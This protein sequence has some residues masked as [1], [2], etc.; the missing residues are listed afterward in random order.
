MY[1]PV[2]AFAAATGLPPE[3]WQAIGRGDV[4]RGGRLLNVARTV[5][6][7]EV[8]ELGKTSGSRRRVPLSRRAL[9]ALDR[10]PPRLETPLLF[11]AKGGGLM[12]LDNWRRREWAPAIEASGVNRPRAS[13][14]SA[15]GSPRTRS[16]PGSPCSSWRGSWARR[17]G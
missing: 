13:T 12:N 6:S 8:V 9:E 1:R 15:R 5:S 2:P 10:L 14:I 4:D 11:P 17:C 7:G 16:L 3:E